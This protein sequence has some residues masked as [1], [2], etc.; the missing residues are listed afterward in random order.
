MSLAERLKSDTASLH[1][2]AERHP[3]QRAMMTGR[4][5]L[6]RYR[7]YLEQVY[8]IHAGID[9]AWSRMRGELREGVQR[10]GQIRSAAL[11]DLNELGSSPES[12]TIRG[13]VSRFLGKLVDDSSKRVAVIGARYVFEGACNG[14]VFIGRAMRKGYGDQCPPIRHLNPYGDEQ[15]VQWQAFRTW[16][17]SARLTPDESDAVVRMAGQTFQCFVLLMEEVWNTASFNPTIIP[18]TCGESH[19]V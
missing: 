12:V 16:L 3:M 11:H 17:D 14:G 2:L 4:L 19:G 15:A 13:A 18:Q 5:E 7:R 1:R 8:F 10:P 6:D 9:V